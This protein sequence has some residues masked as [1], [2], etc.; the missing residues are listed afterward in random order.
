[1]PTSP[2][3]GSPCPQAPRSCPTISGDRHSG[4]TK[5][6]IGEFTAQKTGYKVVSSLV[7]LRRALAATAFLCSGIDGILFPRR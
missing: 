6:K 5:G 4:G 1:M 3:L 7:W 2:L